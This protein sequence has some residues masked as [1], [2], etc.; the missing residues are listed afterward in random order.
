MI[1]F[2]RQRQ[3]DRQSTISLF[4]YSYITSLANYTDCSVLSQPSQWVSWS[5]HDTTNIFKLIFLLLKY[6]TMCFGFKIN[7]L[8]LNQSSCCSRLTWSDA[9]NWLNDAFRRSPAL[10]ICNC[11]IIYILNNILNK[12]NIWKT[13]RQYFTQEI[14]MI[15]CKHY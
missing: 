14:Q 4:I 1:W 2:S 9:I 11:K 6:H 8:S 10:L 15:W 3:T 12:R 13:F 7:I 5:Q